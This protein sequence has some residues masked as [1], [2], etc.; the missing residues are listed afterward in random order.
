MLCSVRFVKVASVEYVVEDPVHRVLLPCDLSL[1]LR[2][3]PLPH[4]LTVSVR[5]SNLDRFIVHWDEL[6]AKHSKAILFKDKII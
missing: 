5:Y 4:S 2:Q 6:K 1:P 3:A